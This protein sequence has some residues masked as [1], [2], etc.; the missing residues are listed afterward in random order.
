MK[1]S[2]IV[3]FRD[4]SLT[5]QRSR[6]WEFLQKQYAQILPEAEVVVGTDDGEEPFHKTVALNRAVEQATGDLLMLMDADTWCPSEQLTE[7]MQG[8]EADPTHW[9]RPWNVKLKLGEADTERVLTFVR[10]DGTA[11][12]DSE[13][14]SRR[15]SLNTY[16]AAPPHLFTR[17]HYERVG[18]FDERFRGWGGEDEAFALAMRAIVGR[19]KVVR[20]QAIHLWHSRMGKSGKDQWPG[21]PDPTTNEHLTAEYRRLVRYPQEMEKMVSNR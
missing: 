17:E 18:G 21:Q 11:P 19:P 2:V 12:K 1:L 7:A 5:R 6:L 8:I 9:W 13:H 3:A 20:G 15:E 16:W 4:S 14:P 10:W